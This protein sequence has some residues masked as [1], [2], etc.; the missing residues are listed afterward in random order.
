MS[1]LVARH[2][3][4]DVSYDISCFVGYLMPNPVYIFSSLNYLYVY[5]IC[6]LK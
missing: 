5:E 6:M 2:D 3:V 1:V 4:D